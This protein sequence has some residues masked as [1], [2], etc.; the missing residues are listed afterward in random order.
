MAIIS[1]IIPA[2]NAET[3]IQA[4]AES[5]LNQSFKDLELIIINDGSTDKTVEVVSSLLDERIHL[6]SY[7]NSGPQK[8]RNRGVEVATGD[9]LAFL[10]AD[11]LWTTDKLE[12]QLTALQK[13]PDCAVA[14]SWTDFIDEF[15]N[16]LPGGQHFRFKDN[17][18]E[19]LLLGD[20]IGSGSNPLIR[21]DALL[22]VGPFDESLLGGQDWEMWIRLASKYPFAL[23]PKTQVFYRQSIGSWSAN[24]ERQERGYK[25]VIE[26][27][28]ATAP[29]RIQKRRKEIIGNRYKFLTF[30]ALAYGINRKQSLMAARFLG[31]ALTHQPIL[32]KNKV[33]WIVLVKIII[34]VL[35]PS[36]AA[37]TVLG[38]IKR[39]NP[40][41]VK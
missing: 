30:D 21:K 23:V 28:L 19:Q 6:L 17:V 18:Y 20:F 40:P 4:T 27:C 26:K 11:D 41:E 25:Q 13:N 37:R 14:Y 32:L 38:H 31:T 16:K 1:V 29:E 24:L 10:D 8:S 39:L 35:L 15:G 36:Q 33:I 7:P 3:T 34:G 2:Y 9:Y 12:S 5:V 22:A